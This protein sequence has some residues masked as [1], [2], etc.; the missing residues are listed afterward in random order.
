MKALLL[1][2]GFGNVVVADRIVA[3]VSPGSAPIKRLKEDAKEQGRLIDATYGRKTRA[4]VVTESNHVIL[5]AINPET[6]AMRML[7]KKVSHDMGESHEDDIVD[8][9]LDSTEVDE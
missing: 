7:G 6:A 3:I 8:S 2:I 5:S 9:E 1:N 4:I